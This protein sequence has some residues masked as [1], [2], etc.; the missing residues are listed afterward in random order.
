MRAALE[1]DLEAPIE[2]G[3]YVI[4][5]RVRPER[6]I[7][8]G[9][10]WRKNSH[11]IPSSHSTAKKS[12]IDPSPIHSTLPGTS[13]S[14]PHIW[15][16]ITRSPLGIH[17]LSSP[18][19][20]PF[21]ISVSEVNFGRTLGIKETC[22]PTR[23]IHRNRYPWPRHQSHPESEHRAIAARSPRFSVPSNSFFSSR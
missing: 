1:I 23:C 8:L 2:I 5:I 4:P 11:P 15:L 14:T 10:R 7:Q 12:P 6:M 21:S 16:C 9:L 22:S 3:Q 20:Q 13:F 19:S 18:L 17:P